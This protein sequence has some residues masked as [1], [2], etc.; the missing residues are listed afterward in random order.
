MKLQI[1]M[2]NTSRRVDIEK[3]NGRNYELWKLKIEYLLVDKDLWVAF[4]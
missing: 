2:A 4:S 1:E 3:F